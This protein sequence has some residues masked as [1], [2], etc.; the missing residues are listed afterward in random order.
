MLKKTVPKTMV[1]KQKKPIAKVTDPDVIEDSLR[2]YAIADKLRTLRLRR[3]MGLAQLAEHTGLSARCC[4]GS[5]M[6]VWCQLC[7]H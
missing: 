5:R 3:S 2:P 4:R 1:T 7:Q 6:A